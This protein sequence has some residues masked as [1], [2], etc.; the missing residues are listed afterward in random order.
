M[1]S[2]RRLVVL[3]IA[4]CAVGCRTTPLAEQE[5]TFSGEVVSVKIPHKFYAHRFFYKPYPD[6]SGYFAFDVQPMNKSISLFYEDRIFA[7]PRGKIQ[8]AEQLMD[9]THAQD[10]KNHLAP[11]GITTKKL[12]KLTFITYDYVHPTDKAWMFSRS[13]LVLPSG[14]IIRMMGRRWVKTTGYEKQIEAVLASTVENAK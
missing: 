14:R 9:W 1:R 13:V 7:M 3:A 6:E 10:A 5:S 4:F 12:G 8:T 11:L 2:I